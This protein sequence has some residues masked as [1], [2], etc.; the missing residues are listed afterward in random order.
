M[1]RVQLAFVAEH[2]ARPVV[3]HICPHLPVTFVVL[4]AHV[5]CGCI[6]ANGVDIYCS[7]TLHGN[8]HF[9]AHWLRMIFV[10]VVKGWWLLLVGCEVIAFDLW[11]RV[12]VPIFSMLSLAWFC[13]M[14]PCG[15]H[16]CL[17]I[18]ACQWILWM[19]YSIP[20]LRRWPT[21]RNDHLTDKTRM[22]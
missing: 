21:M 16:D 19:F 9:R 10:P 14:H 22:Y 12:N 7:R 1:D 8:G 15:G 18:N 3:S 13:F 20:V 5:L 4:E 6:S 17:I 11:K 2:R